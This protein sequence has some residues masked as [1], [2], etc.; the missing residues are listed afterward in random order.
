M[1]TTS[2][3]AASLTVGS[4][5]TTYGGNPLA[6]AVAEAAL[7]LLSEPDLLAAVRAKHNVFMAGL[8]R[9][10]QRYGVFRE[11][12]GK[13]L[14]LGCELAEPWRGHSRDFIKAALEATGAGSRT[15]M[16]S[17]WPLLSLSLTQ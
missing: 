13:G 2:T 15:G 7:E 5:G 3:I 4:H 11:L 17:G 14:L 6:C 16:P 1:L 12:R 10:N 9:L 8:K